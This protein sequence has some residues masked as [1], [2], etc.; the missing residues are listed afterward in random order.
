MDIPQEAKQKIDDFKESMDEVVENL[1]ATRGEVFADAVSVFFD[2]IQLADTISATMGAAR[3]GEVEAVKHGLDI[4]SRL[5]A[6]LMSAAIVRMNLTT[7]EIDEARK[8]AE[9]MNKNRVI[10]MQAV[11][12]MI[13]DKDEG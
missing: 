10:A 7:D 5:V 13:N 11:S 9:Q 8:H 3:A 12:A 6:G 1:K 4:A 2:A